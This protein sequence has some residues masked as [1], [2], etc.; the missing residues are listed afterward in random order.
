MPDEHALPEPDLPLF[1]R[2]L[3]VDAEGI[4]A[5]LERVR[6]SRNRPPEVPNAWQ[7]FLGVLRMWHRVFFRSETIG[8]STRPVRRT[9]R[10]RLMASRILRFPFLLRARA[11]APLDFSG[12]LSGKDRVL[13]HLMGAHHEHDM[14]AYD[15][16]IL[17]LHEGALEELAARV[18]ELLAGDTPRARFLRDLTVYEG[19]HEDLG[20]AVRGALAGRPSLPEADRADP[21]KSFL[22]YLAWCARQPPTPEE[23]LAAWRAG[24]F[25]IADGV[26]AEA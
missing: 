5:A 12:L 13:S 15:L 16:E 6:V 7:V 14:F 26:R 22:A 23:T 17:A 11:V 19:Y 10:A 25:G 4:A 9:L 24:R 18:E 21:D 20:E 1:A 3:L 8:K 2:V